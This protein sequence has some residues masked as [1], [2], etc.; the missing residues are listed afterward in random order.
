[1][2]RQIYGIYTNIIRRLQRN[3]RQETAIKMLMILII[4]IY[5]L[6]GYLLGIRIYVLKSKVRR[7]YKN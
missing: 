6:D 2:N 3:I 5:K 4:Y 7:V 1:M